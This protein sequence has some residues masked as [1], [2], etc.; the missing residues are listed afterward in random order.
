MMALPVSE[1]PDH[2]DRAHRLR[3]AAHVS[4]L[5]ICA[6]ARNLP[7]SDRDGPT[8]AS[9]AFGRDC[10]VSPPP[11]TVR[12]PTAHANVNIKRQGW[13]RRHS[14]HW[15]PHPPAPTIPLAPLLRPSQALA[16]LPPL[17]RRE[18]A[19]AQLHFNRAPRAETARHHYAIAQ[20]RADLARTRNFPPNLDHRVTP[21][22]IS[23]DQELALPQLTN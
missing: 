21:L 12:N 13:Y 14:Q 11:D 17:P 8:S 6:I 1:P 19:S 22:F 5:L 16:G 9:I 7:M 18:T 3:K 10:L 20:A 4:I 23:F 2:Y 15:R